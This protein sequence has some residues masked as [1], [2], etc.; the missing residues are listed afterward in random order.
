[1]LAITIGR[2]IFAQLTMNGIFRGASYGLIGA[3]F[4]LI[5]GVTGRLHVWLSFDAQVKS[6]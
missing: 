3:G 6:L 5:L 2:E 1:M 4:A